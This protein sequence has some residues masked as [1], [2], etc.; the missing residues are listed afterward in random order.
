MEK[1]PI[2]TSE[3]FDIAMCLFGSSYRLLGQFD[4]GALIS[5]CEFFEGAGAV[6]RPDVFLAMQRDPQWDQKKCIFRAAQRFISEVDEVGRELGF[7]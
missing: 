5:Q 2:Q 1:K 4:W 3:E 7:K 6:I